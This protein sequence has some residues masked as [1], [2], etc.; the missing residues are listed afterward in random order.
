M[1]DYKL[2]CRQLEIFAEEDPGFVPLLSNASALLW[3]ALPDI[4]WAGFYLVMKKDVAE[5]DDGSDPRLTAG[6]DPAASDASALRLVLG[7]F[8]GKPA[9][10]HIEYGK[11]VCGTAWAED[12][13]QLVADVH[14]FPGHIACDSASNSEI[15]VPIHIMRVC[16]AEDAKEGSGG[17]C[18]SAE[19]GLRKTGPVAAVLDIDSP[20]FG[21][22]TEDDKAGLEAFVRVLEASLSLESPVLGRKPI[23]SAET[24][25]EGL[26]GATPA[27]GTPRDLGVLRVELEQTD[28]ELL[29]LFERRMELSREVGLYK[30]EK[31]LPVLDSAKEAQKIRAAKD[32]LP[33]ELKEYGAR[34][35]QVLMDLGKE[36]QQSLRK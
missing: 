4:N 30:M 1:T 19:N 16:T 21:R 13:T 36:L 17:A 7:P 8:Q 9:C 26:L 6:S 25:A 34:F 3:E 28:R 35:Q 12:A 33:D 32:S 22:F 31:G 23:E 24:G 11:G 2:L 10:I 27:P 18:S 15:V 14:Q 20:L 29:R 5:D